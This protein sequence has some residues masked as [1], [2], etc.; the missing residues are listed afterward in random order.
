MEGLLYSP[1]FLFSPPPQKK[2]RIHIR[3]VSKLALPPTDSNKP[4]ALHRVC[5]H[6][7]EEDLIYFLPLSLC[8]PGIRRICDSTAYPSSDKRTHPHTTRRGGM[9]KKKASS[10]PHSTVRHSL[11]RSAETKLSTVHRLT[12]LTS[13]AGSASNIKPSQH[14]QEREKT[15]PAS[16]SQHWKKKTVLSLSLSLPP[17][18]LKPG[19]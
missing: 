16:R 5:K 11:P 17:K 14:P 12:A 7:A 3:V 9:K 13:Q 6:R 15:T 1:L 2:T 4:T 19:F 8:L 10:T 18:L